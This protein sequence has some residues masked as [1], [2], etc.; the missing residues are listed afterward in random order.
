MSTPKGG[1]ELGSAAPVADLEDAGTVVHLCGLDDELMFFT[2]E[3][4]KA[5]EQPVT[6]TVAGSY[7]KRYRR[8]QNAQTT[9]A[10]KGGGRRGSRITGE[11]LREQREN[12]AAACVLAWEGFFDAGKP[13]D[14]TR[15][16]AAMVFERATWIL[17]QVEAA[18]V[19]HASFFAKS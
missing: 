6:I 7:S 17:E 9:R 13:L 1:F 3:G 19:D 5:K 2:P 8:A 15:E 12:L 4:P 16:N 18:Q 10:I 11:S 14:C